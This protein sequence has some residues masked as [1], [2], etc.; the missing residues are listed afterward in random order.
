MKLHYIYDPLCAWCYGAIGLVLAAKDLRD[1]QIVPHGVGLYP[2]EK[3]YPL[4]NATPS[5]NFATEM[6][7]RQ[8]QVA[9]DT[10][11]RFAND[12]D[13]TLASVPP[14]QINSTPGI[15]AILVAESLAGK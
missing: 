11:V 7:K 2:Y 8:A 1:I 3:P 9:K 6:K 12:L 15:T 4:P 14:H 13:S 5:Q 10:G